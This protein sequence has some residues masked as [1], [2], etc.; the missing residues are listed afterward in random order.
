MKI[1]I[2]IKSRLNEKSKQKKKYRQNH[3]K[4]D[5]EFFPPG[6]FFNEKRRGSDTTTINAHYSNNL[7]RTMCFIY[8]TL[9]TVLVTE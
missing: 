1:Y 9:V 6:S 3:P 5:H 4:V 7:T 8:N 2:Y